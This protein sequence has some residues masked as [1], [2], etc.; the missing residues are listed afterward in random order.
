MVFE[1][2]CATR[3]YIDLFIFFKMSDDQQRQDA[4]NK[5]QLEMAGTSSMR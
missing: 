2:L 1:L 5:L 4:E 3:L